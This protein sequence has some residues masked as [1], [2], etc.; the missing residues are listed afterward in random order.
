MSEPA[1]NAGVRIA[2]ERRG[3]GPPVLLLHGLG[4]GRW[5]WEP[6]ADRLAERCT[7]LL[8]DNRGIGDS[9]AP[10][11]PYS[12]VDL[13]GDAV[14]VLDAAGVERAAVVGISLGGMAAQ[15]LALGWPDRV[16]SLV[17]VATTPGGPRS[18]PLPEATARMLAGGDGAD[19]RALVRGALAPDAPAEVVDR[20]VALRE[21][22]AQ[23]RDSWRAQAAAALTFDAFD[24][25][26]AIA[27]PT[28]VVHGDADA[29]VDRRNAAL[30]G[31]RIRGAC[32]V[33]V[34]GAG[35][36]VPW[37]RPEAL[38]ELVAAFVERSAA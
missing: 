31:E 34:P 1:D 17:L 7:V 38:T 22:A 2:Y 29:V 8:V 13:A 21:L 30:L 3:A 27:A 9:D 33:L 10:P 32:V 37:D 24:R 23:S 26:A 35:H 18:H 28:L 4:Y 6:I 20:I 19:Q 11:G 36:L 5:G 12:A 15:E 25:L 16:A 14:A